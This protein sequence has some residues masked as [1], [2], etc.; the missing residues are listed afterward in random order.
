MKRISGRQYFLHLSTNST[1]QE[2]PLTE[3]SLCEC[4]LVFCSVLRCVYVGRIYCSIGQSLKLDW[5]REN[6]GRL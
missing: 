3:L 4:K 2:F 6:D 5:S 1:L